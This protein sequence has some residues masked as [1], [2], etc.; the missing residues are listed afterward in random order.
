[1]R[2]VSNIE[3]IRAYDIKIVVTV[4]FLSELENHFA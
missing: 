4:F 3:Y 2:I 1:M